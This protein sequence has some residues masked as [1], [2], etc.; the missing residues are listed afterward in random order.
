MPLHIQGIEYL[1]TTFQRRADT[2]YHFNCFSC[3]HTA[4]N[5]DNG[6][7]H[8]CRCT[9]QRLDIVCLWKKTMVTRRIR[10]ACIKHPNLAFE[11]DRGT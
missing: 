8:P 1:K 6:C 5:P 11:T 4:D 7:K 9:T 2:G 10:I 3:L